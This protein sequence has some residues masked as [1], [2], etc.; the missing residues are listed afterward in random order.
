MKVAIRDDLRKKH[1]F[2]ALPSLLIAATVLSYVGYDEDV[3]SMLQQISQ[4][5]RAYIVE[6]E[7]LPG[8]LLRFTIIEWL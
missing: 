7:G 2:P 5:S 6:R 4:A 8:F 3:C 1:P